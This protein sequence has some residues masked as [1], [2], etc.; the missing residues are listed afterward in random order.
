MTPIGHFICSSTVAGNIDL[1]DKKET[2]F[3]FLYY[4]LFLAVFYILTFFFQPGPWAMHLHDWAGNAALLFFLIF[5]TRKGLREQ[6]FVCILIGAMIL[7]SYTHAADALYLK[8]AGSIPEGMW[9]PHNI[10]HTPLAAL[11]IPAVFTP[12]VGLIM[13]NKYWLKIF[14]YL[15]A[16]YFLHIV[17]DTITYSYQI[18]PL[19]PVSGYHFS[20]VSFFQQPDA[21]SLW[22]GNPLYVFSA[23][24]V[25]N[26]DGFI[27]Y[28][29]E[30]LINLLLMVLFLIKCVSHR[31]LP[32]VRGGRVG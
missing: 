9:R 11:V 26:I 22:L 28:K 10:L 25:K 30:I 2:A 23:P 1:L 27:V 5:W 24:D 7:S 8:I 3:C 19:W 4:I 17:C 31:L 32:F 18:Y 20:L 15:S 6:Y 21:V 13:K 16:G 12:L 14:F 29:A